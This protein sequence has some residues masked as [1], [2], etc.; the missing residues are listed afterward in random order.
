MRRVF[1]ECSATAG[2]SLTF[3]YVDVIPEACDAHIGR[4]GVDQRPA[5]AAQAEQ[6]KTNGSRINL[7]LKWK[8]LKNHSH[9]RAALCDLLLDFGLRA[10]VL[11]RCALIHNFSKQPARIRATER[12]FFCERAKCQRDH[13][14]TAGANS[15]A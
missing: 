8:G 10:H 15:I 7:G 13:P 5:F 11:H 6:N 12:T 9:F 1:V 14:V 4:V 2:D 3:S